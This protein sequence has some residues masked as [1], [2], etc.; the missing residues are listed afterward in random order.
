MLLASRA[1]ASPAVTF[2]FLILALEMDSYFEAI[3]SGLV[4][5]CGGLS[6]AVVKESSSSLLRWCRTKKSTMSFRRLEMLASCLIHLFE[7]HAFD[8]RVIVPLLKT[9][10]MLLK[11][12]ILHFLNVKSHAF[13]HKLLHAVRTEL[14][15]STDIGKIRLCIEILVSLLT[16][17]DPVRPASLKSLLMLVGH[18]FPKVRKHAADLLYLQLISDAN[19]VG[20]TPSE[21]EVRGLNG[22]ENAPQKCGLTPSTEKYDKA[23]DLLLTTV[24]DGNDLLAARAQREEL[25]SAFGMSIAAAPIAPVRKAEASDELTSYSALVRDAGY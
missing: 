15:K 21:V 24:W 6:E 7:R 18:R 14:N 12:D 23:C 16:F 5:S 9:T 17:D 25:A 4:I 10:D 11:N 20:I 19:A 2:N 3:I 8:D 1:W 22:E 13:A